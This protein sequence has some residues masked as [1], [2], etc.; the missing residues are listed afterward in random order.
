M[1]PD[2]APHARGRIVGRHRLAAAVQPHD[3][4]RPFERAQHEADTAVLAQVRHRLGAAADVVVVFDRPLVEDAQRADRP[5]R[6]HV[7]VAAVAG[8]GGDEEEPLAADPGCE[9]GVDAVE[10]F[11]HALRSLPCASD[12]ATLID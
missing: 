5:L 2:H 3:P 6:R 9:L 7:H 1:D 8:S 4:R 12:R 10:D 11:A